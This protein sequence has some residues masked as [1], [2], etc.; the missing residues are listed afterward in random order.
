MDD[1]RKFI[2]RLLRG[3]MTHWTDLQPLC[4]IPSHSFSSSISRGMN[5]VTSEFQLLRLQKEAST[6][7]EP[8]C[9]SGRK[10]SDHLPGNF[11]MTCLNWAGGQ[12]HDLR[13]FPLLQDSMKWTQ[14]DVADVESH[15]ETTDFSESPAGKGSPL[16]A[17]KDTSS[18]GSSPISDSGQR[19]PECHKEHQRAESGPGTRRRM[20][21]KSWSAV[22]Q[23]NNL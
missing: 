3:W 16:R 23:I 2:E 14:Q 10:T 4:Q 20:E 18:F 12:L 5:H 8:W 13:G 22:K 21:G 1:D 19:Q 9:P 15:S 7:F 17:N 11:W 6:F